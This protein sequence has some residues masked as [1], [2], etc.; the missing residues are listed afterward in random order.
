MGFFDIFKNQ[1]DDYVKISDSYVKMGNVHYGV[2]TPHYPFMLKR[3]KLIL[4]LGHI[5][6]GVSIF[7]YGKMH[8]ALIPNEKQL[9]VNWV[10]S[11]TDGIPRN[12]VRFGRGLCQEHRKQSCVHHQVVSGMMSNVSRFDIN[13]Y[14]EIE[15]SSIPFWMSWEDVMNNRRRFDFDN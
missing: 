9:F 8:Y 3:A 10:L 7:E 4:E 11:G 2:S 1:S 14:P 5:E 6:G 15:E 12:W 13:Y